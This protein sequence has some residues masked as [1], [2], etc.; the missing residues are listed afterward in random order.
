MAM[1]T[2]LTRS[3]IRLPRFT[4]AFDDTYSGDTI[5]FASNSL[6][7]LQEKAVR[8]LTSARSGNVVI[9]FSD[10]EEIVDY[11]EKENI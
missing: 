3:V 11:I 9:K 6:T 5:K 1:Q 10:S 8:L 2:E 7:D 4:M